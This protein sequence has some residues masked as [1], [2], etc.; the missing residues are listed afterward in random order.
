MM[1]PH[2]SR[3]K[4]ASQYLSLH[5]DAALAAGDRETALEDVKLSLRLIEAIRREP[6]VISYLVRIAQVQIA[7]SP[8]WEGLA[9]RQWTD[10]ELSA[11]ES[12][13]GK[14]DF[15]ADYQ[16][17]MRGERA[18]NLWGVDYIHKEGLYGLDEMVASGNHPK[19]TDLGQF[20]GMASFRLIPAGWFDQN[21]L[22]LCRMHEKYLLRLVG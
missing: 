16:F 10:A 7:L 15:M 9:D 5:A 12:E 17:A 3:L 2:L 22:S 1:I 13:L 6:I 8:V 21:E 19:P 14:L 18:C 11:I 20:L 4:A